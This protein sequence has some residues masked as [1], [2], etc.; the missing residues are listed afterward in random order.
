MWIL[1]IVLFNST[2][3]RSKIYQIMQKAVKKYSR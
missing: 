3:I 1:N 2:N